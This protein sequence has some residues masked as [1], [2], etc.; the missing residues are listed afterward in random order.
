MGDLT[1]ARVRANPVDLRSV[2]PASSRISARMLLRVPQTLPG[3]TC[4]EPTQ[5]AT[6]KGALTRNALA[7]YSPGLPSKHWI[8]A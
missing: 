8:L 4:R 2:D 6:T 5:R 1:V 3:T 7:D